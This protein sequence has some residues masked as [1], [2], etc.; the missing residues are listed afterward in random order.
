MLARGQST[1]NFPPNETTVKLLE[2]GIT[3]DDVAKL[4]GFD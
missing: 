1:I 3:T 4:E 2:S